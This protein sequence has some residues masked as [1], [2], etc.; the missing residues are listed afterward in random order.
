MT[1]HFKISWTPSRIRINFI[2]LHFTLPY[3]S[4]LALFCLTSILLC[5]SYLIFYLIILRTLICTL[6]SILPFIL[7]STLLYF[8]LYLAYLTP[9]NYI[10]FLFNL[11]MVTRK[12]R[13]ETFLIYGKRTLV[14][15]LPWKTWNLILKVSIVKIF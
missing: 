6:L 3:N 5:T 11:A 4:Y 14:A 7:P 10:F 13:Q 12:P 8:A 15:R 9:Y 2:L 1:R